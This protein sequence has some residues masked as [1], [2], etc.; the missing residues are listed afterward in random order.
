MTHQRTACPARRGPPSC[1]PCRAGAAR[2]LRSQENKLAQY[3]Q[4]ERKWFHMLQ[5][6]KTQL[7]ALSER[8]LQALANN[9]RD[10]VP[11]DPS[12]KAPADGATGGMTTTVERRRDSPASN[13][14]ASASSSNP[15]QNAEPAPQGL[16]TATARTAHWQT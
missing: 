16:A 15:E 4:S 8:K 7:Q 3:L 6:R 12:A 5:H 13:G 10:A 14:S 11:R 1:P 9:P 2:P